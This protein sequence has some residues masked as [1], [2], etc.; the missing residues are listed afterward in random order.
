MENKFK[1][2]HQAM[3][4]IMMCLQ[5]CLAEEI[6]IVPL[7]NDLV[8]SVADDGSLVVLNPPTVSFQKAEEPEEE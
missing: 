8:F 5:K 2:N 1:L 7:L 3:G 6:D 4:A